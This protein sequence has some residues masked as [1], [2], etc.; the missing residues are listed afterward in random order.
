MDGISGACAW[1]WSSLGA[2]L[3]LLSLGFAGRV[4]ADP[5]CPGYGAGP[6]PG[7]MGYGG[8]MGGGYGPGMSGPG[9]MGGGYG[10]GQGMMGGGAGMGPGMMGFT[11]GGPGMTDGPFASLDL[12]NEQR[13]K[14][15][16]IRSDQRKRQ[17]DTMGKMMDEQ[18]RLN[19]L[20]ATD[21]PDPKQVGAVYGNIGKLQQQMA[22]SRAE[23]WNRMQ[24]VLTP[25]QK[26]Q[27]KQSRRGGPPSRGPGP[28]G[29]LGPGAGGMMGR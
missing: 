27:F 3:V 16:K 26:E 13:D 8:M 28:G 20:Y 25:E 7:A 23:A 19:E 4:A 5:E 15:A 2:L 17:W 21:T 29:P 22:E 14:L 10:M 11:G 18:E 1:R 6:G 12:T 24:S 9:M